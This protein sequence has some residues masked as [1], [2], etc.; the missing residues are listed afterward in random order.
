MERAL[1]ERLFYIPAGDGWVPRPT[2]ERGYVLST[3]SESILALKNF[4]RKTHP[5][6]RLEY[7]L[8]F[9][10][11]K[12]KRYL[13]ASESL[14]RTGILRK[15][16][17]LKF[18]MKFEAYNLHVKG[19]PSP[20]GINPPS[21]EYLVELGRYIKPIEK[22][23]YKALRELFGFIVVLKGFNQQQ[24]GRIISD[25]WKE[26]D[27]P[28]GIAADASK[29]EQSVSAECIEVERLVYSAYYSD[30][31]VS[32]L[33]GWQ[34][35]YRGKGSTTDGYLSFKIGGV[36]ASGMPNTALGNCLLSCLMAHTIFRILAIKRYRFVCDGD[37]VHFIMERRDSERFRDYARTYYQRLGFRMKMEHTVDVLEHIDFCQ[38][39]PVK[40]NGTYLMVRN[41]INALS[42]D[43]LAKKPL[44]N[45]KV[46][47]RWIAAV[48]EGGLS[49]TGGIPVMQEYYSSL[50]RSACGARPL[51]GDP[52]QS[53]YDRGPKM[54]REYE[55]VS[56]ETRYSFWLAFGIYPDDQR[57]IENYYRRFS[58]VFGVCE[59]ELVDYPTLPW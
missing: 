17:I 19:N 54:F 5:L 48:G 30:N 27:D 51:V 14:G 24:R 26:F 8:S 59:E 32:K 42:K 35:S 50:I 18:F 11:Q 47:L 2:H 36:R 43:S 25:Y 40:V 3:L 13:K 46:F 28:I 37:D 38:S 31:V 9:G 33:M 10:G 45:R 12:Q 16:A 52:V 58:L 22:L 7:S 4:S 44:D 29:F 55:S 20:R 39:R 23:I 34:K 57:A 6:D 53:D 49:M 21:D 1:K 15:H 41:V 56:E